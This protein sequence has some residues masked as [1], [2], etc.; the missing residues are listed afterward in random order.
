MLDKGQQSSA[1]FD[2]AKSTKTQQDSFKTHESDASSDPKNSAKATHEDEAEP[3]LNTA[4]GSMASNNTKFL[5]AFYL[6]QQS[7]RTLTKAALKSKEQQHI[8]RLLE[9]YQAE[10]NTLPVDLIKHL[11]VEIR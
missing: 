11:T 6:R 5:P 7:E 2:L 3:E 10:G 8:V 9:A 4:E 1:I